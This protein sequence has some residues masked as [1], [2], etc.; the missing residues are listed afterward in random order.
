MRNNTLKTLGTV[1]LFLF[2]LVA[3]ESKSQ[4]IVDSSTTAEQMVANILG[5][6][7]TV[8]NIE[9]NCDPE[10]SGSFSNGSTTNI[11]IDEGVLLTTGIIENALGPNLIENTSEN[12]DAPGDADLD[13]I[14]SPVLTNDACVLEFD[15][16]AVDNQIT[17]QYVFASEEYNEYVCSSFNDVFAFFVSGTNPTGGA[18]LNENV[19]LVPGEEL[20]VAINNVNIGMSGVFG[21]D[22]NCGS[23]D[24]TAFYI[25]N[26]PVDSMATIAY[27]GFTVS[28]FATVNI[29]PGETYH[30]KFAIAD[31][32]DGIFD[33][34]VFLKAESF[35]IFTCDAGTISLEGENEVC[36]NDDVEDIVVVNTT[37]ILPDDTYVYLLTDDSG[38]ILVSQSSNSISVEPYPDGIY[39]I[40]GVSYDE[41]FPTGLS[42][43]DNVSDIENSNGCI[44]VSNPLT[45]I[46]TDCTPDFDCPQFMANIGDSCD[47]GDPNTINDTIT[48][49]CTCNGENACPPPVNDN[50]G[51]AIANTPDRV[52]GIPGWDTFDVGCATLS[53]KGCPGT[54]PTSDSWYSFVAQAENQGV[55]VRANP[56]NPNA[57]IIDMAVEI[58]D[59]T[60]TPLAGLTGGNC[61]QNRSCFNNYGAGQIERCVPGGLTI[62]ATYFY[63]IY[64]AAGGETE[65]SFLVDTKVKT[66]APHPILMGCDL[67]GDAEWTIE[68]PQN[69]YNIPPVPVF[70]VRMVATDGAGVIK[71]MTEPKN[72]QFAAGLNFE[73]EDFVP[74]LADGIYTFHAQNEVKMMANGCVSAYWSQLGP[75]CE[76]LIGVAPAMEESLQ[77]LSLS[78]N[79]MTLSAY[80]NP[81]KGEQVFFD[82]LNFDND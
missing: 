49:N 77:S 19:A 29:I 81:N 57:A 69:L 3:T 27:D 52:W 33:S 23:L 4:L 40:Y 61:E 35:S 76:D 13:S 58:F 65:E 8:S 71:A 64:D 28:L 56:A 44:E 25:D 66:Y 67:S 22:E 62:G 2:L 6:G 60:M 16:I 75:G 46:L 32:S 11:G 18:Y 79:E 51:G 37:S 72:T 50:V 10:G 53:V 78:T 68:S 31:A 5:P 21:T 39:F 30:F 82:V 45:I 24:N 26:P 63:R 73:A 12:L 43:G 41:G 34:G 74:A 42:V 48:P 20:P 7:V 47:D 15:F 17:V 36:T 54:F 80:P 9:L 70:H 59:A 38:E 55:L 1:S 14:V